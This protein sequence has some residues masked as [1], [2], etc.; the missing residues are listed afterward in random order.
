MY[1][2]AASFLPPPFNAVCLSVIGL[3]V[4][5]EIACFLKAKSKRS[6]GHALDFLKHFFEFMF[7][8]RDF[9]L[10]FILSPFF[11]LPFL[12]L[13]DAGSIFYILMLLYLSQ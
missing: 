5:R 12:L 6:L 2:V 7:C 3:S 9:F 1:S 13:L 4:E 11:F 10:S 8:L